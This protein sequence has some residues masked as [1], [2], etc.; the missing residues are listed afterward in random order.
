MRYGCS[1]CERQKQKG[2]NY[3]RVC[4]FHLTKGYVQHVRVAL[5][6]YTNEKFCGYCGG[7]KHACSCVHPKSEQP[8]GATQ[9]TA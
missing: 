4:G 3:C 2:H 1:D 8:G 7:E 5:A 6:H 9:D